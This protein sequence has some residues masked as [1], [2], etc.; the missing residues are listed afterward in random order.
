M[1]DSQ[2]W[3]GSPFC[4]RP[5]DRNLTDPRIAA[6]TFASLSC[7]ESGKGLAVHNYCEAEDATGELRAR[8]DIEGHIRVYLV[9]ADAD[10]GL[11]IEPEEKIL[12]D[13][14]QDPHVPTPCPGQGG[15]PC[16]CSA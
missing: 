8:F 11:R 16:P 9:L 12:S 13:A 5:L 3:P 7:S 2:R 10:G 14:A 1:P 6:E 4:W 15:T